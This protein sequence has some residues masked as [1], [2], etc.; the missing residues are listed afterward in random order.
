MQFSLIDSTG[1]QASLSMPAF[2]DST[3]TVAQVKTAWNAQAALLDA[4]AGAQI[5]YGELAIGL[6]GSAMTFTPKSP[7]PAVGSAITYTANFQEKNATD[8]YVYASVVP[9]FDKANLIS[10]TLKIDES[11]SNVAAYIAALSAAVLGGHFTNRAFQPLTGLQDSFYSDRKR[12][13][14]THAKSVETP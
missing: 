3:Q 11:L 12:R 1:R 9:G 2:I 7:T 4:I 13:R 10:G 8:R 14:A 5:L 6:S